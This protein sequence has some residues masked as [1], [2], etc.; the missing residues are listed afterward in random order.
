MKNYLIIYKKNY[1]N[2]EKIKEYLESKCEEFKF[3]EL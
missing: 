2:M 3:N 1:F